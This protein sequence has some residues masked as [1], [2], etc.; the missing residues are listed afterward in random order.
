MH[1]EEVPQGSV[2]GVCRIMSRSGRIRGFELQDKRLTGQA[3][4]GKLVH[5]N[6]RSE[7]R[8]DKHSVS[9]PCELPK[10]PTMHCD[11]LSAKIGEEE[12]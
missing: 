10:Y 7:F 3:A 12:R 9:Q 11:E 1:Q 5:S 4:V 8:F 2:A 6:L